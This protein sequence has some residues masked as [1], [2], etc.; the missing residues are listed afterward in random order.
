M[1][2]DLTAI[3]F[4]SGSPLNRLSWLRGSSN[5]VES[6]ASSSRARWLLY[7][8]GDPLI[9]K[10][11]GG[12]VELPTE[13]VERLL[14]P[15]PFFGQGER[16]G[17]YAPDGVKMLESARLRGPAAVF[18]GVWSRQSANDEHEDLTATEE[19][20]GDA[21]FAIDVSNIADNILQAIHVEALDSEGGTQVEYVTGRLA[22][23][24]FGKEHGA[25]FAAA[26]SM[27]DWNSRN[28]V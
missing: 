18:L 21:Y 19:A 1:A 20:Q 24:R 14:G 22:A 15:R 25:I 4:M 17:E 13:S 10:K 26:R 3:N 9:H 23:S 5:R 12:P 11:T 6:I 27:L 7:R 2:E 16:D 28:K 8:L